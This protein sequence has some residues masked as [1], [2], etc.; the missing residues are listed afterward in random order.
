MSKIN[1]MKFDDDD[2]QNISSDNDM[3]VDKDSYIEPKKQR[4]KHNF[5]DISVESTPPVKQNQNRPSRKAPT[6][7]KPPKKKKSAFMR[8]LTSFLITLGIIIVFVFGVFFAYDSIFRTE[9]PTISQFNS[10]NSKYD[11]DTLIGAKDQYN[12]A[13]FGVD[14][15]S[16]INPRTDFMMIGSYDRKNNKMRFMS[17]PRDTMAIMPQ[18]RIQELKDH[19]I[20]ILFPS[21]GKMK[22]NEVNHHATD[23]YGSSFLLAQLEEMF[24]VDF[25]FYVKIDLDG[26]KYLVDEMGGVPFEVPQRMYYNDPTEDL[27]IDLQEGYQVLNGEQA[28][29]VVR[30]RKSDPKNPIS[31]GYALGDLGRI[32]VQQDFIAAFIKQLSSKSNIA[33]TLP[34]TLQTAQKYT[35]TN[36][37]L[38]DLPIYIPFLTNF[39][40]ENI[41]MYTMP[42]QPKGDYVVPVEPDT[43]ELIDQIFYSNQLLATPVS[44]VGLDINVLN[45][46]YTSGVA[47]ST[48]EKLEQAGFSVSN[49]GDYSGEKQNQTKIYVKDRAYG[50]DIKKFFTNSKIVHDSKLDCDI[51]IVIGLDEV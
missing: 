14:N 13:I 48:A 26:F 2:S 11:S 21:S 29:G 7:Q 37:K 3:L 9:D 51:K 16:D 12:F 27:Y 50:A 22:L 17:I 47:K 25:D 15:E 33:K 46:T 32:D 35:E 6:P 18:E 39:S 49:I 31:K 45:G 28:E 42:N 38:K 4:I 24:E 43:S 34:A 30:Y 40:S 44:S 8:F 41:E 5:N 20:P 1:I 19:K 10:D 23:A 36:F